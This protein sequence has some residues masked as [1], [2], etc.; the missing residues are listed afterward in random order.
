MMVDRNGYTI[1]EGC[2]VRVDLPIWRVSTRAWVTK[3][4]N[5]RATL[6]TEQAR[7]HVIRI[8]H[9]IVC[10][11]TDMQRARQIGVNKTLKG[12]SQSAQRKRGRI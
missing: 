3:L 2:L 4:E 10:K 7:R 6:V 12:I 1:R 9:L 11:P 5:G 8:E